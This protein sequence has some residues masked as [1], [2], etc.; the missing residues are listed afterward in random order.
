MADAVVIT[1]LGVVSAVGVGLDAFRAALESGHSALAGAGAPA[2]VELGGFDLEAAMAARP[3]GS[4][5]LRARV[6]RLGRRGPPGVRLALAAALEAWEGAGLDTSRPAPEE[7]SLV[8]AGNNL[9]G[10]LGW[11]QRASWERNPAFVSP[12]LALQF[13]DTDLVGVLSEALELRGEGSTVGGAS[14]SGNLALLHGRR[15]LAAGDARVCLVVGP[16]SDLSPL[17]KQSFRNLGAMTEPGECRPFDR[18]SRGFAY[19]QGTAAVVL[20]PEAAALR[21]GARVLAELAAGALALDG[22]ALAD[23][24]VAGEVRVMREALRRAGRSAA[25]VSYV[26][27]HGTGSPLGDAVEARAL[28][29]VFA[30]VQPGP[31]I[32]STKALTGHCLSAAGVIE[33]VATVLALRDGRVHANPGLREPIEPRLRFVGRRA[34]QGELRLALSNGFGFGGINSSLVLARRS[35]AS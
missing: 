11:E 33:A 35:S 10:R 23:P 12:R 9:H 20:E 6:Q 5:P 18:A 34:E 13:Q 28:A 8:V 4:E 24:T 19:G 17:E 3:A 25:E 31:W 16:M 29:E 7:A 27:A 15:L 22:R 21:R 30:G 32:N 14:A 2:E 26:N 1:G